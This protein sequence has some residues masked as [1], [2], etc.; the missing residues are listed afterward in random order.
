[1]RLLLLLLLLLLLWE[2][3]AGE[4]LNGENGASVAR[5]CGTVLKELWG[6][7]V[8]VVGRWGRVRGRTEEEERAMR[9]GGTG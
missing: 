7:V 1:M 9:G 8:I 4:L 6:G 5:N 2:E 3:E